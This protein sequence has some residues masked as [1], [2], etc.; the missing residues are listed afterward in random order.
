MAGHQPTEHFPPNP[1]VRY[2]PWVEHRA[3]RSD[4]DRKGGN[5]AQASPGGRR[6]FPARISAIDYPFE[7]VY[8]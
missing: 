3:C 6:T 2:N 8:P 1:L 7:Q 5:Q 4:K